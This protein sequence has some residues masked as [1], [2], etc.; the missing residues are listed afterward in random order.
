MDKLVYIAAVAA[1]SAMQRQE[2]VSNNI[3]NIST[4][5][6]KSQLMAFQAAPIKSD[7]GLPTRAYSVETTVGFDDAEGSLQST[8][9]DLDMAITGK[10]WFSVQGANNQEMYTRAGSFSVSEQGILVN[11]S[12]LTIV[13][14]GGEINIPQTFRIEVS[15]TGAINGFDTENPQAAP[16]VL[17]QLK[18]VNPDRTGMERRDDGYFQIKGGGIAEADESVRVANGYLENSNVNPAGA[19]V[20]MITTQREFEAHLKMIQMA[21]ENSKSS[22]SLL[23]LN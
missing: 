13:G 9:R 10:G 3:A 12:G 18:L 4:P 14:E 11:Q 19:M 5:G 16:V 15:S 20:D 22:N 1:K 7:E 2:Q 8:G 6:F 21:E 23:G 17:G